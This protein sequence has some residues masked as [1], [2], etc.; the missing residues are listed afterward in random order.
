MPI[1]KS[2]NWKEE[3]HQIWYNPSEES[4]YLAAKWKKDGY[5]KLLDFGCGLGRHSIY[6][7]NQGFDVTAFDLSIDGVNN[8]INWAKDEVL[9]IETQ[10][11]GSKAWLTL[12]EP[13]LNRR[14]LTRESTLFPFL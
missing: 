1:S 12:Q 4:Y 7:S 2:W 6:F 14:G 10:M 9:N 8:L 13:H 5:T 11:S 3:K